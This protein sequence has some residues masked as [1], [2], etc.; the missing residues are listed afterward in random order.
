MAME[1]KL[2]SNQPPRVLV[3][4]DDPITA[5]DLRQTLTDLGFNVPATIGNGLE[6]QAFIEKEQVDLALLDIQL[7]GSLSGIDI[8]HYINARRPIPFVFLTGL[9]DYQTLDAA[10][11]TL[12]AAY[13]TKPF[14][15]MDLKASLE[16]A[17]HNFRR[18]YRP[19]RLTLEEVNA[20]A[21]AVVTP[22]EFDMLQLLLQ[23]YS[24]RQIADELSVSLSTVKTHLYNL[25]SKLGVNNRTATLAKI[26]NL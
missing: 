1:K 18:Q 14:R 25:Y 4:E 24:N 17:L 10:K 11:L 23:G 7:S 20:V 9:A 21:L 3:V 15:I 16:L 12:P 22:R 2:P 6:V 5:H 26:A 19:Y 13:L 8:A